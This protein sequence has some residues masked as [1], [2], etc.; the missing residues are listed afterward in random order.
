[1]KSQTK[2]NI[3]I[4]R[5]FACIGV[6]MVHLGQSLKFEGMLRIVTDFGSRGVQMFFII[7]GYLIANSFVKYGN[8]NT[9]LFIRKKLIKLLPLYYIIMFYYFIMHTFILRNVP[10]DPSGMGWLRYLLPLNGIVPATDVSF[11]DNLGA[12]WTIPYFVFAYLML[13]ICLKWVKTYKGAAVLMVLSFAARK[14]LPLLGG[15]MTVLDGFC[16]FC[17]GVFLYYVC[18][19]RKEKP[20]YILVTMLALL[21]VV[22]GRIYTNTYSFIFMSMVLATEQ[23]EIHSPGVKKLLSVSDKYSYTM[24]LAHVI[25]NSHILPRCRFGTVLEVSVAVLGAAVLTYVIYNFLEAPAQRW[26]GKLTEKKTVKE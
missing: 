10:H 16:Y 17:E 15:W 9:G 8:Q 12:T 14:L 4:W 2:V 25:V 23:M 18:K 11:W 21:F 20:V 6:F 22:I 3:Q 24:Y 13:P 19:D 7:S 5:A 1:M 26:L